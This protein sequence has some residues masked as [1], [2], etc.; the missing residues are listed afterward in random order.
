MRYERKYRIEGVSLINIRQALQQHPLSFQ[1]LYPDRW[2]NNVYLDTPALDFFQENLTGVGVRRKY[3]IRWYGERVS[4]IN[5]PLLEI[6]K[7]HNELGEKEIKEATGFHLETPANMRNWLQ[8]N[9]KEPILLEPVLLNRYLRSYLTSYDGRYRVTIDREQ[10]FHS[11]DHLFGPEQAEMAIFSHDD[12]IVVEVKYEEDLD[13]E[14]DRFG[15]KFPFRLTKNSKY[16][17][18]VALVCDY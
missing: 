11:M 13:E 7:K 8:A 10:Q 16:V 1:E 12:A 9:L 18:G 14:W 17:N 15:R 3:R 4:E 5:N 6:K 2:I